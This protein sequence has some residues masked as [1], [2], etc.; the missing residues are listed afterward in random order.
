MRTSQKMSAPKKKNTQSLD[1]ALQRL[2]AVGDLRFSVECFRY[3]EFFP[4]K[5]MPLTDALR[6]QSQ[7]QESVRGASQRK[8]HETTAGM[9]FVLP[10]IL[11]PKRP[12]LS[13]TPL[14]RWPSFHF[15]EG[16]DHSPVVHQNRSCPIPIKPNRNKSPRIEQ[17]RTESKPTE[18]NRINQ[19]E[20]N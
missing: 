17:Y 5:G 16:P 2:T 3:C 1:G 20:P 6:V 8:R 12:A 7:T 4:C 13:V 18:S 15:K 9:V 11:L 10:S 14:Q 19:P